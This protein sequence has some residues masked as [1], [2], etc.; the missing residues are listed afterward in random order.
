MW[1]SLRIEPAANERATRRT[2]Y[3]K[4]RPVLFCVCL[5]CSVYAFSACAGVRRSL[6]GGVIQKRIELENKLVLRGTT[7]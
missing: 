2:G 4:G 5:R 3:P 1:I 7:S 6:G